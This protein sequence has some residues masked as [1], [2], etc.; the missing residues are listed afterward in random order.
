[1]VNDWHVNFNDTVIN[2]CD[3]KKNENIGLLFVFLILFAASAASLLFF[4]MVIVEARRAK[5]RYP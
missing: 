5:K 1:M 2:E 4:A 3:L